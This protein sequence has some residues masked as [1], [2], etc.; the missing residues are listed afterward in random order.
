MWPKTTLSDMLRIHYPILQAPMAGGP[1]TP[2]LVAA[3]S[4]AGA[5]GALGGSYLSATVLRDQIRAVRALTD[6]PFG[7]NL[8]APT[9]VAAT[10]EQIARAH[11]LLNSFRVELGLAPS[12]EVA[13]PA[14]RFAEGLAVVLEERVPVFSFTFGIPPVADLR[15]LRDNGTVVLGTAT[16]VAEGMQLDAA[17][18]DAIVGQ[19]SE[20]GGHRGTFA[21]DFERGLVGTMALVPQLV[22]SVSVPV[23]A[24][25]GIMDGRGVVAA[26]ALGAVGV[27]M[28]TAFL[29]TQESGAHMKHKAA[30]LASGEDNTTITRV[31]SGKPARALANRF[32][33]ELRAAEDDVAPYPVQNA[34][35]QDIRRTAAQ[36][37]RPEFLSLWSGQAPRLARPLAAAEL[38]RT[39]VEET[40]QVLRRL[41]EERA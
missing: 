12:P 16:T 21:G 22:D 7:V 14:D 10:A 9:D 28:G 5:L 34:L 38:V 17:G 1:T 18:V 33:E 19:G 30:I 2:E 27:Q 24:A 11:A 13:P 39:L 3:V 23:I 41:G 25:G 31:F 29:V 8:F 20:A 37:N 26:L 32:T 36:Q 35:T 4:N 15:R 6:R 40:E